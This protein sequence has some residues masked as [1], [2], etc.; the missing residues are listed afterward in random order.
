M[1]HE[2]TLKKIELVTH[3]THHLVFDRPEGFSFTPG[4]AVEIAV[5]KDGWREE[6]R[7]FTMVSLPDEPTLE[8]VIKTY[9]E[10]DGVTEQIGL[11][12][13][14]DKVVVGDPWGAIEDE[15]DGVFIAGG[16]G[17]TPFIA[18][19][20]KKLADR[21][22][23]EGNTLVFSNE[24]EKDIILKRWFDDL[25]GLATVYT[26]TEQP[27]SKLARGRIDADFLK[28]IVDVKG[29]VFYICG[30]DGMVEAIPKELEKL[31]VDEREVVTEDFS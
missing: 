16:A 21:G 24:E 14:G 5:D 4:Q 7:P 1:T 25:P 28:D 13:P 18:I 2:L 11:L 31:G 22:T 26:V 17:V 20:R 15:G 29:D 23:L 8:F 10:H 19:L 27:E 30:P 12:V 6:K 3:D 9:P